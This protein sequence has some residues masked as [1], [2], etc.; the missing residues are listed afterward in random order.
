MNYTCILDKNKFGI[1]SKSPT[2]GGGGRKI[3]YKLYIG[4][5]TAFAVLFGE[6]L[7]RFV[8][9]IGLFFII[10]LYFIYLTVCSS[11]R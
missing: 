7:F 3:V 11:R 5:R 10:S 2:D 1:V 6:H 4:L 9:H 8:Y